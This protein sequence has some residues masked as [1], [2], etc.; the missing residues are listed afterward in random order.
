[1][2]EWRKRYCGNTNQKKA[3]VAMLISGR[4]RAQNVIKDKEGNYKMIKVSVLQGDIT[5]FNVYVPNQIKLHEAKTDRA[6]RSIR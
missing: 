3:G 2:N 5:V 4:L 6:T 1:M